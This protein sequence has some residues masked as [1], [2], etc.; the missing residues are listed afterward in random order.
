MVNDREAR[1][2]A[3]HRVTK[4]QTWL[5]DWTTKKRVEK[6]LNENN[7]M[8]NNVK[9]KRFEDI[10]I[11]SLSEGGI[12]VHPEGISI[13]IDLRS[14]EVGIALK[15]ILW[16]ISSG[17]LLV[18]C[19]Y[20]TWF[21]GCSVVKYKPASAGV[22]EDKSLI[23]G[24]GRSPGGRNG[25][26]LQYSCLGNPMDRGGWWSTVHGGSKSRPCLSNWACNRHIV[27]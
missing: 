25:N 2:A 16:Y 14:E 23:P 22:A 1:G 27:V 5:S 6:T 8:I 15:C 24:F 10:H 7:I 26:S 4:S 9:G 3:V 20:A 21:P 11:D 18:I 17:N 12:Q 19:Y 13:K